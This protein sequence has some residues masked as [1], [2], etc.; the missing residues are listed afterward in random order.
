MTEGA[1]QYYHQVLPAV[2]DALMFE[3]G[4]LIDGEAI[5]TIRTVQEQILRR[6]VRLAETQNVVRL[7]S[8]QLVQATQDALKRA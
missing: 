7:T 3:F 6:A 4:G 1:S 5:R 8:T 2:I